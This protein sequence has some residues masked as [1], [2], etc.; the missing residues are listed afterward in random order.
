MTTQVFDPAP[1]APAVASSPSRRAISPGYRRSL[2]RDHGFEPLRVTGKLPEGLAGTLVR[3]GPGLF[4]RFGQSY[5]HPFEG[6]GALSAIRLD[7]RGALG[8]HRIVKGL[9]YLEEKAAGRP[10]YG[11]AAP[12]WRRLWNGLRLHGKNTANTSVLSWQGRLFALMEAAKPTEIDP[13]DLSTLG[14]TD[15][16]GVV[17]QTFSA[18]P[19]AIPA[20]KA[21]YNFGMRFGRRSAIELYALP[22]AGPARRLGA[23]PLDRPLMVHDFVAT[24]RHLVFLLSPVR[25]S[26]PHVLLGVGGFEQIIRWTPGDGTE[27]I[28]VPIDAPSRVTRFT[29]DPFFQ[30]HFANAFEDTGAITLDLVRY[31]DVSSF[32]RIGGK[33][34]VQSVGR[35]TRMRLDPAAKTLTSEPR[36]DQPCEFPRVDPRVEGTAHRHIWLSSDGDGAA[37]I[38]CVDMQTGRVRLAAVEAHQR[39][40]E[41]VLV[42]RSA[43]AP[44][45]DGWVLSLVYDAREHASHLAVYDTRTLEDGPVARAHFDHHVPMTFHG[46]WIA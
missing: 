31:D 22:F 7:G 2:V 10:L 39:Q 1:V 15:L 12:R 24:E 41:P 17:A 9:G 23:V 14:E 16:D 43:D 33:E 32:K 30:W 45:G 21:V 37:G 25:I 40:S 38:A 8:A 35:L 27:V 3:N 42:P 28:V 34:E 5:D 11:S 46:A 36:W 4:E 19:H 20:R 29:V 6:D 18:H 26:A 13:S 44:E